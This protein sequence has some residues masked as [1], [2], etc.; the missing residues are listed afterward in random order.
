[1]G[2][3]LSFLRF[4]VILLIIT[5]S[6]L[7]KANGIDG[8]NYKENAD[9]SSLYFWEFK[10]FNF[11]DPTSRLKGNISFF[12][13]SPQQFN[14]MGVSVH[15]YRDGNLYSYQKT[16]SLRCA[17]ADT[18]SP[19]LKLCHNGGI[20][21]L[22][23]GDLQISLNT[24]KLSFSLRYHPEFTND[25]IYFCPLNGKL[26]GKQAWMSWR[27]LFLQATVDGQLTLLDKNN[28]SQTFAMNSARGYHDQNWG[29]WK[30]SVHPY[31]W[32][33]FAAKDQGGH[34]IQILLGD[35]F[36]TK[37]SEA[38]KTI[39]IIDRDGEK[40]TYTND[41]VEVN[42]TSRSR[43]P[44]T[45]FGIFDNDTMK[46]GI[47]GKIGDQNQSQYKHSAPSS[48]TIKTKDGSVDLTIETAINDS[49]GAKFPVSLLMG[50]FYINEQIVK[51]KGLL[52][53]ADMPPI[54]V[55]GSG[56]AQFVGK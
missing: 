6:L 29:I 15:L 21:R 53:F 13:V 8:W 40:R 5:A 12:V 7:G 18:N 20:R 56:E 50:D 11:D 51:T 31:R 48:I 23:N 44:V 32:L 1:L 36:N 49:T 10:Y 54:L 41:Q 33:H 38:L 34:N 42:E 27:P 25:K 30:P 47:V 14:L 45:R 17:L 4:S 9:R 55:E 22:E 43:F 28:F 24:N 26:L 19:S 35:F 16:F 46:Q 2:I 37:D 3:S 39:L 52:K